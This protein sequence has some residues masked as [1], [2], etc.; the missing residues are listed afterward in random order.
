VIL[1]KFQGHTRND[2][3]AE[4]N[5]FLDKEEENARGQIR[6]MR[7]VGDHSHDSGGQKSF[8]WFSILRWHMFLVQQ[9]VLLPP[10]F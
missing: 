6:R 2:I 8:Y 7:V 3:H 9:L 5:L 1:P 10:L 4:G